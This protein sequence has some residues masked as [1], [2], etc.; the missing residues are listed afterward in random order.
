MASKVSV[1]V[2]ARWHDGSK[3][4]RFTE[5][6]PTEEQLTVA[7]QAALKILQQLGEAEKMVE[8]VKIYFFPPS[9]SPL[10]ADALSLRMT[11]IL[12]EPVTKR[13]LE[14]R[15]DFEWRIGTAVATAQGLSEMLLDEV[16]EAFE[17]ELK[18]VSAAFHTALRPIS[19]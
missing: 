9:W 18:I 11:V 13:K 12:V 7:F 3:P 16:R 2:H 4:L 17:E 10:D 6:N 8:V 1:D 14:I 15:K 19:P 5:V